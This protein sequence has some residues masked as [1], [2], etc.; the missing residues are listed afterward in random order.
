MAHHIIRQPWV[1]RIG[2]PVDDRECSY[3][4]DKRT[5]RSAEGKIN[6]VEGDHGFDGRF[7][8][9]QVLQQHRNS[10]PCHLKKIIELYQRA[11]KSKHT[12]SFS[13]STANRVTTEIVLTAINLFSSSVSPLKADSTEWKVA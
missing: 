5:L 6:K 12:S 2:G 11:D 4:I 13:N 7:S 8:G 10:Q 3:N 1:I 9:P